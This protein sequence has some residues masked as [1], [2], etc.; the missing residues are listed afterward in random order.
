LRAEILL[1][2]ACRNA[3][4]YPQPQ[5]QK[6]FLTLARGLS[7]L[8]VARAILIQEL[9]S[10]TLLDSFAVNRCAPLLIS[11][12]L[13][14]LEYAPQIEKPR[15]FDLTRFT[16]AP[17]L[18]F[19]LRAEFVEFRSTQASVVLRAGFRTANPNGKQPVA[20]L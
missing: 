11:A 8:R 18:D 10:P 16:N 1:V 4:S 9:A 7:A 5:P 19:S 14:E 12:A 20:I 6:T 17:A 13:D 15:S 3:V 2:V